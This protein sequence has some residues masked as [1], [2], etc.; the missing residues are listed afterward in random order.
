ML[1]LRALEGHR[2]VPRGDEAVEVE[3]KRE[4]REME[5][6]G[7]KKPLDSPMYYAD[8]LVRRAF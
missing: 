3:G 8:E 2:A 4:W 5:A 1:C 6:R 7:W